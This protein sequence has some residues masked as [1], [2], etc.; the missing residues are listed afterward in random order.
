MSVVRTEEAEV[1]ASSLVEGARLLVVVEEVGAFLEEAVATMMILVGVVE[2]AD[3]EDTSSPALIIM[4][5]Y[6]N[7]V[8]LCARVFLG[9]LVSR[10]LYVSI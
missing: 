7:L 10:V 1:V 2:G 4:K 3:V 5:R 6:V 8:V 9:W